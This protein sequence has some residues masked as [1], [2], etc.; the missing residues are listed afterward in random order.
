MQTGA[1]SELGL[2]GKAEDRGHEG[3]Q[4]NEYGFT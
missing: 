1:N 3:Q 2:I 4:Q